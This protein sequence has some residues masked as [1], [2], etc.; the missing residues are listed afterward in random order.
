MIATLAKSEATRNDS[1]RL[2]TLQKYEVLGAAPDPA[3]DDLTELA[4]KICGCPIAG[5]AFAGADRAA[6]PAHPA[7]PRRL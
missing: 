3:I 4:A 2:E 6:Q 7:Q 5:V 1:L